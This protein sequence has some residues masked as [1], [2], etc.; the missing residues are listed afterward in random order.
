MVARSIKGV[1][2]V[3]KDLHRNKSQPGMP[4]SILKSIP[5]VFFYT[6]VELE[7]LSLCLKRYERIYLYI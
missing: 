6:R 7:N 5:E 4:F 3:E 1:P 2:E